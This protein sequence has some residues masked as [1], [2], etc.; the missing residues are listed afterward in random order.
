MKQSRAPCFMRAD[1]YEELKEFADRNGLKVFTLTNLLV[2]AGLKMMKEGF[3]PSE[4]L[5]QLKVLEYLSPFVEV[6]PKVPW[7]EFGRRLAMMLK[8]TYENDEDKITAALKALDSIAMFLGGRL[9]PGFPR[10]YTFT[11][12]KTVED[13]AGFAESLAE[14]LGVNIS[15]ERA[16][17][18][19]R[20]ERE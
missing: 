6:R 20:V 4:V 18:V 10:Q 12:E 8:S 11:D 1:L 17:L 14:A 3:S 9:T 19:V 7:P 15:V 2:D 5:I 16:F 13:F